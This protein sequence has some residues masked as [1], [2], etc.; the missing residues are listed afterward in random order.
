MTVKKG[1]RLGAELPVAEVSGESVAMFEDP[2]DP[3]C[4]LP[5]FGTACVD[6]LLRGSRSDSRH[7]ALFFTIQRSPA[8]E[9]GDPPPGW[10]GDLLVLQGESLQN[11]QVTLRHVSWNMFQTT[12][13]LE[14]VPNNYMCA[15]RPVRLLRVSISEG[16]T[17]A[18]SSF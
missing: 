13:L 2:W 5:R 4:A 14:H 10:E 17:Q 7:C 11:Q 9:G 6:T 1:K 16:L 8:A 3:G 15:V 12:R 18:N